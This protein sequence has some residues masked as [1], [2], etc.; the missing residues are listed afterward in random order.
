MTLVVWGRRLVKGR[1][2][3]GVAASGRGDLQQ[4]LISIQSTEGLR[5]SREVQGP[6]SQDMEMAKRQK[7]SR[8]GHAFPSRGFPCVMFVQ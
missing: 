4:S 7:L 3:W 1:A 5:G 8:E 6:C 2:L